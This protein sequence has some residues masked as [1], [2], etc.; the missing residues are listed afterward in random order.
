MMTLY[1]SLSTIPTTILRHYG[2]VV[3]AIDLNHVIEAHLFSS[4][5]QVQI[6]LVSSFA[7]GGDA[8]VICFAREGLV[9][10]RDGA[11]VSGVGG[12]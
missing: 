11:G 10:T 5:S 9:A 4:E 7:A 1:L 8:V 6:L 3:K 2:R 12:N